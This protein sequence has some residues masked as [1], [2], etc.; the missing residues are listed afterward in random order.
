MNPLD[1]FNLPFEAFIETVDDQ[2]T[3]ADLRREMDK[4]TKKVYTDKNGK[5][6]AY[7]PVV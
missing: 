3:E 2:F 7:I 4:K 6:K 1:V 5:K